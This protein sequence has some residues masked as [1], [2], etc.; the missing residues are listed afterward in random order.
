MRLP[1][2]DLV[3]ER[4]VEIGADQHP[5]ADLAQV[6]AVLLVVAAGGQLGRGAGIDEG[7]EVGA[8]ID[9][10]AQGQAQL[11][12]EPPGEGL[13][14]GLD[15]GFG[16]RSMWF[17]KAWLESWSVLAGAGGARRCGGTSGPVEPCWW[18]G[19]RG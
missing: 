12:D 19:R 13:L 2:I 5:Q 6:A 14:D 10:R 3:E 4:D 1:R 9:Q 18:D 16:H 15:V 11:L 7:E 8:V 17:Q